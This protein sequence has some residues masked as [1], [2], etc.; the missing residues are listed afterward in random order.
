M[1]FQ[2][3]PNT[4]EI[5]VVMVQ[6]VET[7]T[8][9]FHAEK[10]GGYDLADVVALALLVNQLVAAQLVPIMTND[11]LYLRVEVRGL[12]VENDLFAENGDD[13]SV[14]LVPSE[15][16]PNNVTLSIKKASG[17]TGRSARGRWYVIGL[18]QAD[19]STNENQWLLTA[20]DDAVSAVE[21][22]RTGVAISVWTPVIVSR[23]TNGAPRPEGVTFDWLSVV[24]VDRLVDSQRGR[25]S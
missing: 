3:V 7:V 24:A 19:L 14:G 16:L 8:N 20:T 13:T 1:A 6:N 15:G 2:R 21:G 23:F 12:D 10:S 4:V 25:L 22:I 11:A 5:T 18:P 17:F 9:T